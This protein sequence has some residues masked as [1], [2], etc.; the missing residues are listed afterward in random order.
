[1]IDVTQRVE[2]EC[3]YFF[4]DENGYTR[5]NPKRYKL[6]VTVSC[7]ERNSKNGCTITFESLRRYLQSSVPDGGF[8]YNKVPNG[9]SQLSSSFCELIKS[10]PIP[11]Y[12]ISVPVCA[13]SLLERSIHLL[14]LTFSQSEPGVNITSARLYES[15]TSYVSYQPGRYKYY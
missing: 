5:L 15:S 12:A 1:M 14:E 11:I 7:P 4:L 8:I 6:E 2:F 3:L 10:Y 9:L 13:E